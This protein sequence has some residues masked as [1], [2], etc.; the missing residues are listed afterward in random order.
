M[1]AIEPYDYQE[2]IDFNAGVPFGI[3]RQTNTMWTLRPAS[4]G[5]NERI[6]NSTRSAF[7]S[8]TAGYASVIPHNTAVQFQ[9]GKVRYALLPVWVVNTVYQGKN[10][11]F[12][13]NG[14]TGKIRGRN[15]PFPR[16]DIGHGQE[17]CLPGLVWF[18]A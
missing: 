5:A 6:E 16:A 11:M 12:A 4:R 14:Q 2:A 8:T 10:Y 17:A 1:E 7:L 3:S 13:M 18:W 15:S 9:N